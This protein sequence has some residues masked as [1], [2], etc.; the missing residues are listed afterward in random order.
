MAVIANFPLQIYAPSH[1]NP[2]VELHESP[3]LVVR[4]FSG[5]E[6]ER[7]LPPVK[8]IV[9]EEELLDCIRLGD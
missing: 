1:L 8:V 9:F 5:N 4:I 3:P 6:L 7:G 2:K